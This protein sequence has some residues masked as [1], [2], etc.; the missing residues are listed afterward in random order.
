MTRRR[1]SAKALMQRLLEHDGKCADCGCKTGGPNGLEWDHIVPLANGGD[2]ELANLQ[3]LCIDCHKVKTRSDKGSIAKAKRQAQRTAGI[4]R[5]PV[6][7][8]PGSRNSKW[9]QKLSGEWVL[10]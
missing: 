6:R 8:L 2:D 1:F 5:Q 10:R 9:K 7:P 3:P 4:R